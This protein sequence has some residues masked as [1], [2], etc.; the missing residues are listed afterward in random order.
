MNLQTFFIDEPKK[1]LWK[2]KKGERMRF[3][4]PNCRTEV[5]GG[6]TCKEC[7]QKL[8]WSRMQKYP[9]DK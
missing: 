4:C 1:V 6:N 7:G 2:Q 8:N 3:F 5:T 9:Y